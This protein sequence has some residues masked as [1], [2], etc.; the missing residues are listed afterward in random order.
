VNNA[1]QVAVLAKLAGSG[2]TTANDVALTRRLGTSGWEIIASEGAHPPGTPTG[3]EWATISSY[4]IGDANPAVAFVGKLRVPRTDQPN[5]AGVTRANDMGLWVALP[6]QGPQ[7]LL[8]EGG[9][10]GTKTVRSFVALST[11]S[12]SPTQRR[13]FSPDGRLLIIRVTATDGSQHLLQV[14]LPGVLLVN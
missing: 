13:T 2:I 8:R 5:P 3:A 10:L 11:V 1:D 12:G 4:A 6:G 9:A 7:L 14:Q